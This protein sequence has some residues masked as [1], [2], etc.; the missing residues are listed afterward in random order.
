MG[1]GDVE[2]EASESLLEVPPLHLVE[3]DDA[4]QMERL[5]EQLR[6]G[7]L[8]IQKYLDET[9]FPS[10]MSFASLKLSAS[11][12]ELGGDLLFG[13]RLG[14]SGTPSD[15]LPEEL[16]RCRYETGDDAR[17]VSVLTDGG[18]VSHEVLPADWDARSIL[19]QTARASPPL[20]ALVDSG[21]LVSGFTNREAAA[22][23]LAEGCPSSLATP[24]PATISLITTTSSFSTS[25][26]YH[27]HYPYAHSHSHSVSNLH[28]HPHPHLPQ[29]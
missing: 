29:P 20:H 9:V 8:L 22:F 15:L 2:V 26:H 24:Q 10:T 12:Q 4:E 1:G 13:M 17:M 7:P 19:R 16:G 21:A 27:H 14:F 23:L 25:L 6:F 28:A 3:L 5:H 18:V 11:G